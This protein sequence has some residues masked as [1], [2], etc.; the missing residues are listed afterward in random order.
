MAGI[1][2]RLLVIAGPTASGK[3][4][5]ALAVASRIPCE[6]ISADSRQIYKYLTIGTAKPAAAELSH[7]PHHFIDMLLPDEHFSA[8][9]FQERGRAAI[10]EIRSRGNVPI[11]VGGTGLY[12][13][14]LVDGLF[15]GPGKV[16]AIR[17]ELEARYNTEGG[18]VLLEELRA[19]DPAAA[20]RMIPTQ[21]RRI[22]RALEVYRATGK[23]IT[24]HHREQ[25]VQPEE[26]V[27]FVGLRWER[28]VLYDRINTR[29]EKMMETGF[30]DEVRHL[31][32]MGYDDRLKSLQ[33]VGYKEAFSFLRGE[34]DKDR[35][36]ELMK[37]NTRRYAKRQLTWFTHD[38]RIQWFDIS[39]MIQIGE[40]AEA[41]IQ[42]FITTE[43]RRH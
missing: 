8:G 39:D 23:T 6:I 41:V 28:S 2:K 33:T 5:L 4:A 21:F 13:R 12:V 22:I 17:R 30:L 1:D 38:E 11:I 14:A 24:D 37:Q 16:D 3:T 42:F 34:I 43:A 19:V 29:V 25:D 10:K 9:D 32:E 26:D 27:F 35:M 7:V 15:S 18:V 20:A 36:I 31:M 40:I